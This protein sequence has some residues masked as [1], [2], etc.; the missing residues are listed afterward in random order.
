MKIKQGKKG[1]FSVKL[2]GEYWTVFLNA[3]QYRLHFEQEDLPLY[4]WS[5][6]T[7]LYQKIDQTNSNTISLRG[8]EFYS[9]FDPE[10][11]KYIDEATQI[12]LKQAL[13]AQ[14]S[15]RKVATS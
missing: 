10:L 6:L 11:M 14:I 4:L 15:L 2:D 12:L 7:E 3:I 5:L 8:S 1:K 13:P 9:L